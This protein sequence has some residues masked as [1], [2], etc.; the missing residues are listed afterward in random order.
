MKIMSLAAPSAY[1][2]INKSSPN[3]RPSFK[4][5]TVTVLEDTFKKAPLYEGRDEFFSF[6]G[7]SGSGYTVNEAKELN[8][9]REFYPE[10]AKNLKNFIEQ[11][12]DDYGSPFY[13]IDIMHSYSGLGNNVK[14]LTKLNKGKQGFQEYIEKKYPKAV[15]IIN[16]EYL[17]QYLDVGYYRFDLKQAFTQDQTMEKIFDDIFSPNPKLLS[18]EEFVKRLQ[19]HAKKR[20][21]EKWLT[22]LEGSIAI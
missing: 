6:E 17:D 2:G 9:R 5:P 13:E 18:E 3:V 8:R 1:A 19:E 7:G 4:A 16:N 12:G 15:S 14:I 10:I 11:F 20:S 22:N 21:F